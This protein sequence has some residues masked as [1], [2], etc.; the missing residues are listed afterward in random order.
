MKWVKV[1]RTILDYRCIVTSSW[2]DGNKLDL[3]LANILQKYKVK[4]TFFVPIH[5]LTQ[6]L[7]KN[8]LI[9]LS[10][11]FEIGSHTLTHPTLTKIP[12]NKAY[13]E[14][15]ESKATLENI[16]DRKIYGF[17]Y[18]KGAYD[19][20]TIKCVKKAGYVYARTTERMRIMVSDPYQMG[21]TVQVY[22]S[23]RPSYLYVKGIQKA[24]T[25]TK[26]IASLK[27]VFNWLAHAKLMFDYVYARGGVWHL[28]G[29]SWQIQKYNMWNDLEKILRYV[30][31]RKDVL[32]LTNYEAV[33]CMTKRY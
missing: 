31:K 18:P 3:K 1:R 14:I 27:N 28:F 7:S 12:S 24:A 9:T 4:A 23:W 25:I 17:S 15:A 30:A 16:L 20:E 22:P 21:V 8:D 13:Y 11:H 29:H 6:P 33:K 2:G 10:R 26:N 32:Y 5:F 19:G